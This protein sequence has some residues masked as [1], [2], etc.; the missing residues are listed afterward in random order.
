[1]VILLVSSI[2][3]W[4]AWLQLTW[5]PFTVISSFG[6]VTMIL[7]AENFLVNIK[8]RESGGQ[9]TNPVWVRI[10]KH[11]PFKYAFPLVIGIIS[12]A[13]FLTVGLGAHQ[14]LWGIPFIYAPALPVAIIC[15]VNDV[16]VLWDGPNIE[17]K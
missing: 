13:G 4:V 6:L 16:L 12:V 17:M 15:S 9:E 2:I 10:E 7:V 5:Q 14:G 3:L 1:M 8:V 11:M